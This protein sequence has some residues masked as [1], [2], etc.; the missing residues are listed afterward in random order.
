LR[1][2]RK[3]AEEKETLL[4]SQST[5]VRILKTVEHRCDLST[6]SVKQ[7]RYDNQKINQL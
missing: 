7:Q 2:P 1:K 6:R 3:E 4:A 5:K